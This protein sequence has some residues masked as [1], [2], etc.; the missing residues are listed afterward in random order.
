MKVLILQGTPP[1]ILGQLSRLIE[2]YGLDATLNATLELVRRKVASDQNPDAFIAVAYHL[3]K[4][5]HA[6]TKEED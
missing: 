5:S 4:A 1:Q 3:M 2:E 6:L